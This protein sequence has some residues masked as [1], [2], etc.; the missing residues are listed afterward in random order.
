M[1]LCKI[2]TGVTQRQTLKAPLYHHVRFCNKDLESRGNKLFYSNAKC[3]IIKVVLISCQNL[4][5][6]EI[7]GKDN[8]LLK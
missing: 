7:P 1:V 4:S 3:L 5:F 6:A 2:N 8:L